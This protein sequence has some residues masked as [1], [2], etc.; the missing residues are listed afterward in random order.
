M[1]YKFTDEREPCAICGRPTDAIEL[2]FEVRL[3]PGMCAEE[4]WRQYFA[5]TAERPP[6]WMEQWE[7]T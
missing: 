2:D 6:W 3:H 7:E 5:A 1:S 4:M